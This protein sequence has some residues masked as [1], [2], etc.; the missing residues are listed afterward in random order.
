MLISGKGTVQRAGT[1]QLYQEELDALHA[2]ADS[3]VAEIEG[4]SSANI[5]FDDPSTVSE[6]LKEVL[7]GITSWLNLGDNE[8]FF[9]RGMDSLQALIVVRK[10]RRGLRIP[11]I[12]SSTLYT[13]PSIA[14]LTSAVVKLSKDDT[15]V[16]VQQMTGKLREIMLKEFQNRIDS[17]HLSSSTPTRKTI[18]NREI[19]V[20]TGSKGTLGSHIQG[21]LLS[22]LRVAHIYCLNR[23]T[24]GKGF[25]GSR[26]LSAETPNLESHSLLRI[27]LSHYSASNQ[28]T[29]PS[30]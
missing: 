1:L 4:E 26:S 6:F 29:T 27:F 22:N 30:Y 8:D 13:N 14:Q 5:N 28:K 20:L 9:T 12:A 11:S 15:Y 25:R 3:M 7:L 18:T 23:S 10:L 2:D 17:I 24:S 16:D 21:S 19:I